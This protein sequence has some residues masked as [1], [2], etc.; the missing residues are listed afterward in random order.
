MF[1]IVTKLGGFE[2][3]LKIIA[4]RT[5]RQLNPISV[6]NWQ[7]AGKIPGHKMAVLIAEAEARGIRTSTKDFLRSDKRAA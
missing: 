2:A 3:V 5:G 6:K 7:T 1:P 4:K